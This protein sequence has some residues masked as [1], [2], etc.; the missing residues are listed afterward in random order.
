MKWVFESMFKPGIDSKMQPA[1]NPNYQAIPAVKSFGE[2]PDR[3]LN[4]E[5]LLA[6]F[7][8]LAQSNSDWIHVPQ[9]QPFVEMEVVHWLRSQLGFFV[10]PKYKA[11][12]E[13]GSTL[14]LGGCLSNT[15]TLMAARERLFLG[16]AMS[17]LGM[18]EANVVRVP[19]DE[20]FRMQVPCLGKIMNEERDKG[21]YVLA[22]VAY[23]D[24]SR[25]MRVDN[26]DCLAQMLEE[27]NVWFHVDACHGSQLAFSEQHKHKLKGIEKADSAT[28][29]PHKV[30]WIPNTCSFVLFKN[31]KTLAGEY[32][33][34]FRSYSQDAMVPRPDYTMYRFKSI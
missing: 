9:W 14:T 26:L 10:A 22:C 18:G 3:G 6:E 4:H 20:E 27:K 12:H 15:I 1:V 30:L 19:V 33:N 28:I 8:D 31:P 5:Q 17:W 23:A 7:R 25:S 11:A 2:M 32:I 29:D 34:Q 13:I 21:Q 24:D 16:S